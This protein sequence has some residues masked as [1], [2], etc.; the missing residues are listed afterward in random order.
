MKQLLTALLLACACGSLH[1]QPK[2]C[3]PVNVPKEID[4]DAC[5]TAVGHAQT[6]VIQDGDTIVIHL[7]DDDH[8]KLNDAIA[9]VNEADSQL[10]EV[11]RQIRNS[12]VPDEW[13]SYPSQGSYITAWQRV[14]TDEDWSK[15][16][17]LILTREWF[18]DE[19]YTTVPT[20][21]N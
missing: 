11:K 14:V 4:P 19:M 20:S 7:T 2:H 3:H 17:F 8:K 13:K 1:A 6:Y 21:T 15:S 10:R 18:S 16:G 12:R 5:P 9:K